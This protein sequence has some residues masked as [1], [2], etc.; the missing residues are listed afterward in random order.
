MILTEALEDKQKH[1]G[2]NLRQISLRYGAQPE[3]G[4]KGQAYK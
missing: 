4:R 2:N 3:A 1:L